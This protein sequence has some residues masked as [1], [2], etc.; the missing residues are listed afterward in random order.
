MGGDEENVLR[1]IRT[2]QRAFP[3][4]PEAPNRAESFNFLTFNLCELNRTDGGWKKNKKKQK[5]DL[6]TTKFNTSFVIYL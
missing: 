2:F 5:Q 6:N 4:L 1:Y 3:Q